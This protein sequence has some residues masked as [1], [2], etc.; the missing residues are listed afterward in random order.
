[1]YLLQESQATLICLTRI[2]C[3]PNARARAY[4]MRGPGQVGIPMAG[5]INFNGT[6]YGTTMS[7]G[8]N[9]SSS[10]GCGTVFTITTSGAET[11]L[12]S[13]KGELG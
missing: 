8:A 10:G 12:Y 11:V 6:L 4:L 2:V 9:C 7:G 3:S 1:M 5:L 13:F